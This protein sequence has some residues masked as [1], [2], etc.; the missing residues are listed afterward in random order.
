VPG[1]VVLN[2]HRRFFADLLGQM[3]DSPDQRIVILDEDGAVI[4]T[5]FPGTDVP[6]KER[7]RMRPG[8][9]R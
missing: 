2:I 5:D 3:K 4:Y 8:S 1:V 7:G 6:W 9:A